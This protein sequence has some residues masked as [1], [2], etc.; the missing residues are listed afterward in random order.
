MGSLNNFPPSVWTD[1][2]DILESVLLGISIV[3]QHKNITPDQ[4]RVHKC[5]IEV[6]YELLRKDPSRIAYMSL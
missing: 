1:V 2:F 3:T 5:V 6:L 4:I